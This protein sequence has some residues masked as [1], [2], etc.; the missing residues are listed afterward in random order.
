MDK[1]IRQSVK[2]HEIQ[3]GFMPGRSTIDAT[4]IVWQLQEKYLGKNKQLHFVFVDLEKVFD[5]VPQEVVQWSMIKLRAED[6]LV[7]V[8]MANVRW[9]KNL[10]EGKWSAE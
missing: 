3:F 2:I 8:V 7:S 5:R 9:P 10:C 1:L 6:W 4:F